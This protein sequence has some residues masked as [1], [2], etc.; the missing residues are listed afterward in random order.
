MILRQ[1]THDR[2]N[3]DERGITSKL[4][5]T[6]G[7]LLASAPRVGEDVDGFLGGRAFQATRID[8][9]RAKGAVA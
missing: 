6:R 5:A 7:T 4:P 1:R 8:P 3:H 2:H 9:L